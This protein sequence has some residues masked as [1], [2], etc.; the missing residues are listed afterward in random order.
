MKAFKLSVIL[1]LSC[2]CAQAQTFDENFYIFLGIGQSN[3]QGK[4]D[5]ERQDK[6]ATSTFTE[7][8]WARYKKLAV[9]DMSGVKAGTWTKAVPPLVRPGTGLGV[10]D[11]FG[12]YL[13]QGLDS[14]YTIGVCVVAVDGCASDAFSK[15]KSVVSEYLNSG[16]GSWVTESAK[17][18]GNYPYGKLVE[19]ARIA[20]ESGVIKGIIY[21]QGETD[22][23]SET[24]LKNVYTLYTNLLEDLNLS[25]DSVPFI[26][27]EPVQQNMGGACYGAIPWIDKVPSYFK[28]KSGK[29]C[30]YVVKSDNCGKS[31]SDDYHFSSSGYRLMGRRYGQIML[32][33]LINQGAIPSGV[34]K[35]Q[36]SWNSPIFN[37]QGQKLETLQPGLNISEGKKYLIIE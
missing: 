36:N 11:Y 24:W 27:G 8:D 10:T 32:P 4:G 22:A 33:L 14:I 29:D 19:M 25:I 9:V 13:V 6:N 5:I 34:Q 16:V 30:A 1:I 15:D 18:Y 21:H 31:T 26:A 12:R 23:Y 7:K 3:M 20:Q 17:A 28:E 2:L 35:I 37:I